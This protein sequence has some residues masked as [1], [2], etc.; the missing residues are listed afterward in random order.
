MEARNRELDLEVAAL[1]RKAMELEEAQQR[2]E[3]VVETLKA[4]VLADAVARQQEDIARASVQAEEELRWRKALRDAAREAVTRFVR[5]SRMGSWVGYY[6]K[7]ARE[8]SAL[9]AD[10]VPP[11]LP[12][13]CPEA[14]TFVDDG[15]HPLDAWEESIPGEIRM[16][17]G[18]S[19]GDLPDPFRPEPSRKRKRDDEPGGGAPS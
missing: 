4:Q 17:E 13:T 6:Q 9:P 1:R 16:A 19:L 11:P 10:Q 18:F 2:S 7:H 15:D 5:S 8:T 3:G 14:G 12:Y